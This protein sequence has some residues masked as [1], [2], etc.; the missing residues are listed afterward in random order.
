MISIN[1][2]LIV[3]IINFLVLI[4]ILNRILF[5]PIFKIVEERKSVIQSSR[6]EIERLKSE[7]EERLQN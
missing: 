4:W 3:Q 5:R 1:A 7:A 2:T 6:A